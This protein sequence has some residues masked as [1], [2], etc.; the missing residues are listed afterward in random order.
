MATELLLF[1][2]SLAIFLW[3]CL[4]RNKHSPVYQWPFLG[5]LPSLLLSLYNYSLHDFCTRALRRTGGTFLLKGPSFINADFMVTSDPTNIN[6]IFNKN[7]ANYKKG[8]DFRAIMDPLGDGIFNVDGDSWKFQRKLLHSLLNNPE[9]EGHAMKT[10]ERKMRSNLLPV[11]D[12]AATRVGGD[13]ALDIQDVFKRFM[14]DNMCML[15]LGFD[16]KYLPAG[17]EG[18]R[19]PKSVCSNAFDELGEVVIYRYMVPICVWRFQH[20]L[21]IGMEWKCIRAWSTVDQLLYGTINMKKQELATNKHSIGNDKRDLLTQVLV[22]KDEDGR[23][24]EKIVDK[25]SN[26]FLRD[27]MFTLVAAGRDTITASLTWL[28]WCVVNHPIVEKRILEELG[29]AIAARPPNE[30]DEE[31]R[32]GGFMSNNE[33][34]KLVYLH[35]TV[36]ETLRLYPPVPFEHKCVVEADVLP[37]GHTV[38]K[39]ERI[40]FSIYSMGRMENIWGNDCMEFKPE[41]WISETGTI[42]HIP[43]YKFMTFITGARTCL[44]KSM[45]F[46]QVKYLASA[47]LWNYKFELIDNGPSVKP[48]VGMVMFM[49][50]GLKARVIK[51]NN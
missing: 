26:N 4:L 3:H 24:D 37:S 9:F 11:L 27:T 8:R 18:G 49:K 41:R 16:P 13:E 21:R 12:R 42:L 2:L 17:F 28:I 6:H 45:A 25:T 36:C 40:V 44:G 1:F 7:A 14:F 51:R 10:L 48:T 5:M 39:E 23:G 30:V 22:M 46:T 20:Q 31:E 50:D 29:L 34:N 32:G 19:L 15:V 35:A 38:H 43:S 33:L 47:L